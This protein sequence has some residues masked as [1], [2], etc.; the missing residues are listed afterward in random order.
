M[1]ILLHG[2]PLK[3]RQPSGSQLRGLGGR[4][5]SNIPTEG[6][7]LGAIQCP[8]GPELIV[9]GPD[10]PCEGGYA[11]IG[12]IISAD[13]YLLGQVRPGDT[14]RF[15]SISLEEAYRE[16]W[17]HKAIFEEILEEKAGDTPGTF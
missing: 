3:F 12:T 9:I 8:A 15:R 2:Q 17:T 5:P 11:K 13:F 1:A 10:G 6:N 7:P 4:D 16:L 14:V